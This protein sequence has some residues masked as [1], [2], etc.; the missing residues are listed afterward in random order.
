MLSDTH[1]RL[2]ALEPED[3]LSLYDWENL[4]DLWQ[5]SCT[6]APYS[7]RNIMRYI[8][9]YEADPF[10]EGQLRLM[11]ESVKTAEPVGLVDLYNVEARHRRAC[12]AIL[13]APALQRRGLATRALA[14]LEGY[15]RRHLA[16]HQLIAAVP[17][18]NTASRRLFLKAGFT[19]VATMPQ[20]IASG[21]E[22]EYTDAL[23]F[24]KIL[25]SQAI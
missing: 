7:R 18:S 4:S 6:L 19:H 2:R 1:I 17:A 10:H 3:V 23:V 20:Y 21:A 22:G 16:L 14:L 12:V 5:S 11:A 13:I 8:E 9:S 25:T 15:C 24:N